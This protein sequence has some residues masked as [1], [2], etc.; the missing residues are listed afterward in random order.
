MRRSICISEPGIALAGETRNWNFSFVTAQNLPAKSVLRFDPSSDGR[1]GDWQLPNAGGR[2]KENL[3]WMTLPDEKT[4]AAK[5][6]ETENGRIQFE[7]VLPSQIPQGEKMTFHMGAQGG[8]GGTQSQYYIQRRRPFYLYIDPKAKGEF[9]DPEIFT[10]DVKGNKLNNIRIITPSVVFKNSRFDVIVRFED[11]YGNLTGNAPEG[12]LVELSY[13]QLRENL[14]WKLF[15]PETGFLTLPNLYFN[16]EGIYRLKLK[17]LQTNE[18]FFSAPIKCYLEEGDQ[19]FWGLLHGD[20]DRFD[21]VEDVESAL[22]HFRD[23]HALQFFATSSSEAEGDTTTDEWKLIATQVAEFNEEERFVTMLGFQWIGESSAE[24]VRHFIYA[25]DN[26]PLLRKKD[27]KSNSLKKIYKIHTPKELLSIPCMTMAKGYSYDFSQYNPEF[28]RVVE[29]YNA[30]GSS[31][32]MAKKGNSRPIKAGARKGL[33]E[34]DEG[35]IRKALNRGCRFGFVA[36][37]L[38]K[39]GVYGDIAKNDQQIYSPGLT[40]IL[41]KDYSRDS[42]FNALYN[43]RCYA[44]TG[45]RIVIS[46]NIAG[47][48]IG[49]ELNSKSKPGLNFNRHIHGFIAGTDEISEVTV[50]RNGEPLKTF[51]DLENYFEYEVDDIDKLQ[52][53]TLSPPENSLPFTYYYIRVIQKDG[54]MAWSSPI[55]VDYVQEETKK[56]KKKA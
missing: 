38:D 18:E 45:A 34:T 42:I 7:F 40:S 28:E 35:S 56:T 31:E 32:C 43:R 52:K 15:I 4:V 17:N 2:N 3:I 8:E 51:T 49:S 9:K 10:L 44:S 48:P 25:K 36:G 6:V 14:N 24:G 33:S 53:V 54:H 27:V 29:I 55:W 46:F 13:E 19:M 50:F 41:A 12:S 23:N 20:S 16:E 1:E 47:Q 11:S 22:R 37:G 26:K 39:Q 5:K 30:Y 21:N